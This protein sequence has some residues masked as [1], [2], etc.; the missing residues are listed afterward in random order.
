MH[1]LL[2]DNANSP[3]FIIIS[4]PSGVGKDAT[5]SKIRESG[6]NFCS[7]VT[8][9][10]RIKRPLE[11]D[12]I[13][14]RFISGKDFNKMVEQNELLEWAKVYG[15]YYG[16]PKQQVKDALKSG[17]DAIVKV[18]V[19]GAATIKSILPD[20]LL[21]FLMPPSV[22][23]LEDRLKQRGTQKESELNTRLSTARKEI[24]NLS[25]FDYVVVSYKDELDLTVSKINA[26]VTAEKCRVNPRIVTL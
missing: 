18:D 8:V 2:V 10:T 7:I 17:Q 22:E 4:G 6:F 20:A 1:H 21:I 14:Y 5:L 11:K 19:Q 3:L 24:E 16:I 25:I 26:I 15:S 12:G 13:D 23:D 9:T